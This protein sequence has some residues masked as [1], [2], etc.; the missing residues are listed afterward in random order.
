MIE[1]NVVDIVDSVAVV[2]VAVTDDDDNVECYDTEKVD[3]EK[4]KSHVN[5]SVDRSEKA[6]E[7][8]SSIAFHVEVVDERCTY[9]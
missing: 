7:Q 9:G 5:G 2:V 3:D 8:S 6:N 4:L 1:L